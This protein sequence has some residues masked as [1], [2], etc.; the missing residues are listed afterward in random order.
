[1]IVFCDESF[2]KRSSLLK[3]RICKETK[4]RFDKPLRIFFVALILSVGIVSCAEQKIIDHVFTYTSE[5]GFG[6]QYD[7]SGFCRDMDIKSGVE[8]YCPEGKIIVDVFQPEAG[9]TPNILLTKTLSDM[10]LA[11]GLYNFSKDERATSSNGQALG[12]EEAK[13]AN[14][15]PIALSKNEAPLYIVAA[16]FGTDRLFVAKG[17]LYTEK[18]K[19]DFS[20]KFWEIVYSFE[21]F[22]PH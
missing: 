16:H 13:I 15:D 17:Y 6:Y 5:N 12:I 8:I 7:L 1:M 2:K 19:A 20:N 22:E 10:N 4:M 3:K 21:P 9:Q 18:F 11:P 14:I